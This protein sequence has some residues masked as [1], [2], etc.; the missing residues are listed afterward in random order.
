MVFKFF[1]FSFILNLIYIV[2]F[3]RN[4][5]N[6][7]FKKKFYLGRNQNFGK[8]LVSSEVDRF[9]KVQ[10]I[11]KYFLNIY[12]ILGIDFYRYYYGFAQYI[13]SKIFSFKGNLQKYF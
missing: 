2:Y 7:V 8:S 5:I 6:D 9:L 3:L 12:Q 13:F 10:Q 1:C 11:Y 4:I